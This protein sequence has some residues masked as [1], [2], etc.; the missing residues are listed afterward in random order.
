MKK[1][2]RKSFVS[3]EHNGTHVCG[4]NR[5]GDAPCLLL[6]LPEYNDAIDV[7]H[8]PPSPRPAQRVGIFTQFHFTVDNLV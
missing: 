7:S 4:E 6:S 2:C 1:T 3:G 5:G 8:Y